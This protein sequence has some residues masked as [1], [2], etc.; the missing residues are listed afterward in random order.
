[1]GIQKK[2]KIISIIENLLILASKK[3]S[4]EEIKLPSWEPNTFVA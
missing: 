1:M 4:H 2:V 3:E